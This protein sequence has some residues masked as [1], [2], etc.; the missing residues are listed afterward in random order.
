MAFA[1]GINRSVNFANV[2]SLVTEMKKKG[3]RNAELI[4]VIHAEKVMD[5][6][7]LVLVDIEGN[8]VTK[9]NAE[10]YDL[11]LDGQHRTYAVASYNKS[12][13]EEGQ[14]PIS[15]PAI[16]VDLAEDETIAEYIT[17]INIT[18]GEWKTED[19]VRGAANVVENDFLLK[20][21]NLIKTNDSREG[22]PLSTLNLIY[23]GNS[24]ALSKRDF[25]LL[26][27]GK[28]KKGKKQDKEIMPPYSMDRGNRFI[29]ICEKKGFS[30]KDIAK[31]YLVEVFLRFRIQRND[32]YAFEMFERITENDKKAMFNDKGNLDETKVKEQFQIIEQRDE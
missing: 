31:R 30:Q 5:K 29:Q 25:S 2:A 27:Q 20:Y 17:S 13:K 32:E 23:C 28:T 24:K 21:N 22:Y 26:C 10:L 15:I 8:P 14:E 9:E 6:G 19:Y 4:Q 11:V 3:Y 16:E 18:K 7:D 12:L 1:K